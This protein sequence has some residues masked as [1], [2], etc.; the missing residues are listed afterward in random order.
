MKIHGTERSRVD[1]R[2]GRRNLLTAVLK[3]Y[4]FHIIE[5]MGI[6]RKRGICFVNQA[7]V[8]EYADN[9]YFLFIIRKNVTR[10]KNVI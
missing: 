2:N 7:K 1:N 4:S 9:L 3:S 10:V 8:R 5:N 6:T